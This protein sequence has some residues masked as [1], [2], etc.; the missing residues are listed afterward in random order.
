MTDTPSRHHTLLPEGWE[1][2]R[3]FSLGVVSTGKLVHLAGATGRDGSG[4]YPAAMSEQAAYAFRKIA[5]LLAEAG[6]T[7][8][9]IVRLNWYITDMDAHRA[10]GVEMRKALVDA[11]G[12]IF[13]PMTLLQVVALDSPDASVEIEVTAVIEP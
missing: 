5:A 9:D 1:R 2:P 3:G 11:L 13:P 6:G 8:K 4:A 7:P 10:Q 12:P